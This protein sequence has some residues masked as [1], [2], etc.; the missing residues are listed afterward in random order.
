MNLTE[1][2][3]ILINPSK[4]DKLFMDKIEP[5]LEAYP[6]FQAARML[7]LK[8]LQNEKSFKF[9]DALKKTAAYTTNRSILFDFIITPNKIFEEKVN[10]TISDLHKTISVNNKNTLSETL[11]LGK[12]LVFDATE[13]H[14]FNEWLQLKQIKPIER[15]D[16]KIEKTV[17]LI[18][19]F[20]KTNPKIKPLKIIEKTTIANESIQENLSIMTETL[21]K[22][23][24]E[25]K[26]YEKA[27][28]AYTI[29]ILKYPEKSG[30][31]ADQIR[32]IKNLQKI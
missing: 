13:T 14:S 21:A 31:F 29:L 4:I 30:F 24:L 32:A 1:F 12:P 19:N 20:I 17:D 7:H 11:N 16:A 2:N 27:I 9:N 10:E 8:G 5:V 25:Q 18:E 28:K 26:K 6:Y 22:V 15:Y 3:D 23:Y